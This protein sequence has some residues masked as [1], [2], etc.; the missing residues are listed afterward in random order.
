MQN[1][2]VKKQL[3]YYDYDQKNTDQILQ[4]MQ[5]LHQVYIPNHTDENDN[6]NKLQR[7]ILKTDYLGF[8]RQKKVQC[9]VQDRR[10]PSKTLE[11]FVSALFDFHPEPEWLKIA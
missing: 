7:V 10:T 1:K 8:E 2:T 11:G 3:G 9:H 6:N 4:F 5:H